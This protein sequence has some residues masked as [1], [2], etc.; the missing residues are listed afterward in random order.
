MS[1]FSPILTEEMLPSAGKLDELPTHLFLQVL[2]SG[3]L[4]PRDLEAVRRTC[5]AFKVPHPSSCYALPLPCEAARMMLA[6]HEYEK[7]K[8]RVLGS[9]SVNTAHNRGQEVVTKAVDEA[10]P[11]WIERLERVVRVPAA[12][13]GLAAA[14]EKRVHHRAQLASFA[15][16]F[17]RLRQERAL[18]NLAAL[19]RRSAELAGQ[20]AA[21]SRSSA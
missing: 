19:V 12:W 13:Q 5:K 7:R 14:I 21:V 1:S 3:F 6:T 11:G 16:R 2:A 20:V 4:A 15:G 8:S 17:M 10:G 9:L 18:E